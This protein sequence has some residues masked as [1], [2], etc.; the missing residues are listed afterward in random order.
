ME[1]N[2]LK[3]TS[4]EYNIYTI[5]A[6]KIIAE[7]N[8]TSIKSSIVKYINHVEP[9]Q[10]IMSRQPI[11]A[12]ILTKLYYSHQKAN[13]FVEMPIQSKHRKWVVLK[14]E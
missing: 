6:P 4:P 11:T 1:P 5:N 7:S 13:Y 9:I 12:W 3:G 10:E 8:I 2:H 14:K